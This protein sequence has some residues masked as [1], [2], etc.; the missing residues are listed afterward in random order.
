MTV[1]NHDRNARQQ[2]GLHLS[3]RHPEAEVWRTIRQPGLHQRRSALRL[4]V[5]IDHHPRE[6]ACCLVLAPNR[7][8]EI[9]LAVT[10]E[11]GVDLGTGF[12]EQTPHDGLVYVA[13][14]GRRHN[15]PGMLRGRHVRVP[16][17][18]AAA[19]IPPAV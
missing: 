8:P 3:H 19:R 13:L 6:S 16:R 14:A 17:R 4:V 15:Y 12:L 10:P 1:S 5:Q 18:A 2:P 7:T 11:H 9:I